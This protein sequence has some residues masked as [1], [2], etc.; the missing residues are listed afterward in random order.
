MIVYTSVDNGWSDT[1]LSG[2]AL[3][4]LKTM[5]APKKCLINETRQRNN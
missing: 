3:V 2:E 1:Y 4:C 5:K